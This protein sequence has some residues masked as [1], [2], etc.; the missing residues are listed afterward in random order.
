M[1]VP[2]I[3]LNQVSAGRCEWLVPGLLKEKV[4]LLAKSLPQKV[5]HRLGPLP[6]FAAEFAAAQ[7]P[8]DTPLPQA[9]AR[10]ARET[11]NVAPPLDGFRLETLP[12]H[13]AMNFR[14]VDEHGRQLGMGR[15]LAQLRPELGRE[16][17]EQFAALAGAGA[18]QTA[19]TD[20]SFGPLDEI[21][22]VRRGA[23]RFVG[24]PA[25]VDRGE[26]VDLEVFD[27]PDRARSAHRAGLR[28]LF[29]VQLKEQ[30]RYVEKSLPGM[31]AMALQYASFGDANEL[32]AD[33][34][35][36][37]F[38][39]ACLAEPLPRTAE[40]FTRRRDEARSRVALIAQ[41]LARLVGSILAEHQALQ[42]KLQGAKAFPESVRDV[43]AQLARLMPKGFVAAVPWE[44]LQHFPRYLKAASLRLDKLRADPARDRRALGEFGPLEIQWQREDAR[45]QK[46]GA[47]DPQLEQFRWLLEELRVQLF[48]QELKT[49]AAVSTKRL[50]KL[51]QT[52]GR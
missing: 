45:Q 24:H 31:Q 12:A 20:W 41:E 18:A 8:D 2:L 48:A 27:S 40:E 32:K 6:D 35:A 42:K 16:A 11:R 13:L 46:T 47:V 19:L 37:A 15:N 38:D 28:R 22:E 34:V 44:R 10:Y 1:T 49:A 50:G 5:R 4:Q 9:I 39:R 25:L 23:Q 51:W 43:T 3:A 17:G 7:A 36:A 33:L 21:M 26:T 30:A 14:V 29:M 52:L